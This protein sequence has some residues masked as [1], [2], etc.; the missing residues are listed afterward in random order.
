MTTQARLRTFLAL[1]E[2]G[3]VRSAAQ[4]LYVTESAV[5][6]AVTALSR[7]LGVTLV[8]KAGR[9][10]RLTSAGTVYAGYAR[11]ILGLLDEGRAAAHGEHEPGHGVLRLAAVT[12]AADQLLPAL[13]AGFRRRWP[14]VEPV[15]EVGP[16][17]HVW[18]RLADH[19]ADLV[20]A[21]R[22]APGTAATVLAT[23][24]NELVVVAAP[25]VAA[26]FRLDRT[27]W[28]VR[29]PG[30]G[31]RVTAERY[32]AEQGA[33][34]PQLVLG[35]NGAVIA[36]AAAGLGAALV[37][38]DAVPAEL[39]AGRLVEIAA[40]GTPLHRPW[41]AVAGPTPTRNARLFADHVRASPGWRA[42]GPHPG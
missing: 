24:P 2:T 36:G 40:P 29:E 8:A 16:S 39:T 4:R 10:L 37:S 42:A 7:D 32:L 22:P 5:S 18:R 25:E 3:S 6:A 19:E 34:P 17:R 41:H 21:G 14:S 30:S 35:S 26:G 28:V 1:A 27:P 12:T 31:T 33:D 9:G 23:R 15:L 20:L 11:R 38:R 13:L